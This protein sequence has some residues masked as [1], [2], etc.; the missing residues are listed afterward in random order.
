MLVEERTSSNTLLIK[1]PNG[2]NTAEINPIV[3]QRFERKFL[4]VYLQIHCLWRL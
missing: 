2:K 4:N 3:R 1:S